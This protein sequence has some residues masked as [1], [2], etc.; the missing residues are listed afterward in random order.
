[1]T[2]TKKAEFMTHFA[3][4]AAGILASGIV[5]DVIEYIRGYLSICQYPIAVI[6]SKVQAL[7]PEESCVSAIGFQDDGGDNGEDE[8]Y[9][10]EECKVIGFGVRA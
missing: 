4:V 2:E 6:N 8:Y 7:Q 9:D 5:Q 10:D 3:L 1:M